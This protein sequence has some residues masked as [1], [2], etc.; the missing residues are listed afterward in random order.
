MS[1]ETTPRRTRAR[2]P[3]NKTTTGF[4]ISDELWAVL[5][6]LL[7]VHVN[8]HRFGGGR[9]RVSDR[10]CADAIFYVLRT[11]CQWAA[12]N[13]TDLCAKSTAYD[14]FREWVAAGVFLKLWQVGVEQF[15]ELKGIDWEWLSMD[16]A[17]TKAPL[18]GKKT[19]PN[20]TDRGK[21]GVKRSLLT[22][23]H[24]VPIGVA[25]DGAN[26]HDM[27]LV[28]ATIESIVVER[29]E[30]TEERPQGMCLDKGY[31]YEE[32][33]ATLREFGFTAHIRSRGEEARDIA[34]EAGKRARRWV[35]ERS[36][37]WLNR[38]RRLL[39]RWEKK[40]EHYL[41]FLHFAC[42]LIALRAAGLFG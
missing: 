33:R 21:A 27:K 37:S 1:T 4:R 25:I 32:V 30:P 16:G 18:G 26:R 15:D 29:P 12:L 13:D 3:N 40:P 35:V 31:D 36:H 19:G 8:T 5:E 28:R 20:P 11:G 22:E 9:P 17:M 39:V 38:F 42:G 2:T 14:R 6:P 23:G 10:R 24:G 34:R 7:P 41:A